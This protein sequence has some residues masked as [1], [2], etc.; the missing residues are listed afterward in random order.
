MDRRDSC[1]ACT[2]RRNGVKTRRSIPHT[3]GKTDKELL[4]LIKKENEIRRNTGDNKT[5]E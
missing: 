4:E 1:T 5:G 2:F 3:C